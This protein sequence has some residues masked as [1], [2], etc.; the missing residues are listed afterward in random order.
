MSN[1]EFLE[2]WRAQERAARPS[3]GFTDRVMG[4]IEQLPVAEPMREPQGRGRMRLSIGVRTG[5]VAAAVL[6]ALLRVVELLSVFAATGIE[7]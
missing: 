1:D 6:V 4:A 3:P 5:L 2:R 7:N